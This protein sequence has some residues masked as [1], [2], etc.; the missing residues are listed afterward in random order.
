MVILVLLAATVMFVV[1]VNESKKPYPVSYP[2][3]CLNYSCMLCS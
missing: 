2:V 1:T 3:L